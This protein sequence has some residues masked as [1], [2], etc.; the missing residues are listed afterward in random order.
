M[1]KTDT[2]S[3]VNVFENEINAAFWN[4]CCDWN[5]HFGQHSST[6]KARRDEGERG[7]KSG[8]LEVSIRTLFV[9]L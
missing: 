9:F 6:E 3:N 2:Y 4:G 7:M 1:W 5:I 8:D